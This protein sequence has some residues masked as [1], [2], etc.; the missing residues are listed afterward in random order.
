[1]LRPVYCTWH[2]IR[3]CNFKC[4]YCY[5]RHL[6]QDMPGH[7]VEMDIA[8]LRKNKVA[9]GRINLSG[10]EPFLYPG[11]VELCEKMTGFTR[12]LVTTNCSTSNVMDFA[13]RLDPRRVEEVHCSLHLGQRKDVAGMIEKVLYLRERR[14][15]VY[16]SQVIHPLLLDE[17][18]RVFEFCRQRGVLVA[19]KVMNGVYRLR[20]YPMGYSEKEKRVLLKYAAL[21][22]GEVSSNN[23]HRYA[24]LQG[25][26]DWRG[27]AC[28]AGMNILQIQYNGDAYRCE[29]DHRRLGNLYDGTIKL[30]ES[31]QL[32]GKRRCCE[33]EGWYGHQSDGF[34]QTHSSPVVVG[35]GYVANFLGWLSR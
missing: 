26:M 3:N 1:M 21:C 32:C 9:W 35:K 2:L 25:R 4:E 8:A 13:D 16:V 30:D 31:P 22:A 27:Q 10:G 11:F 34:L 6:N 17:Y 7:G 15:R 20:E 18:R 33:L 23:L 5:I 14:F 28:S 24:V 29:G 19:P 12:I